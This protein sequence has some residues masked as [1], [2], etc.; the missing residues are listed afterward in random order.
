MERC[1]WGRL[2][3]DSGERLNGIQEVSGSIPLISTRKKTEGMTLGLSFCRFVRRMLL[4][5]VANACI[6]NQKPLKTD[7]REERKWTS[8]SSL[9]F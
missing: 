1:L 6:F 9:S 3:D 7:D 5:C 8:M 2:T 4:K